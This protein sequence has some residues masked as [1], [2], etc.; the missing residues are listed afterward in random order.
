MIGSYTSCQAFDEVRCRQSAWVGNGLLMIFKIIW[1]S[2]MQLYSMGIIVSL[3]EHAV[4]D[5]ESCKSLE[6]ILDMASNNNANC[7]NTCNK[8]TLYL[9]QVSPLPRDFFHGVT[10]VQFSRS[11]VSDSATP[12]TAAHQASLSITNSWSLLK[13][14]SIESVMPSNHL[15][16]CRPL[17]L[18]PSIFPSIR[19]FPMSWF[20][21]SGGQRIG[22]SAWIHTCADVSLMGHPLVFPTS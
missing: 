20:L 8:R 21:A 10:S 1:T 9:C 6:W 5:W 15:I 17:L 4:I 11:V 14:M 2:K 3:E 7:I 22:V 13:V 18:P 16:L 19:S 12:W